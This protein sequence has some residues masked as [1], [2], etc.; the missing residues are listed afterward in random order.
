LFLKGVVVQSRGAKISTELKYREAITLYSGSDLSIKNICERTGVGFCAF[1][2]YL[3]KNHRELIIKRHNLS[4]YE[5]VKLRGRRGQTTA[6]HHKYKDAIAACDS[7]EYIE[8]NISQIARIF[9]VE[10]AALS[11][12]LR[13]HYPDIVPRREQE[14]QRLGIYVN[15]QYGVRSWAKESYR[16]AVELLQRSEMTIGEVATICNVSHS[17]LQEH[18]ISYYPNIISQREEKRQKAAG[19]KVRGKRNGNW[20]IHEPSKETIEKYAEAIELYRNSSLSVE[21][22]VAATNVN[23]G[24]FRNYLRTWHSELMVQRRGFDKGV[25]L[26]KTKRY[27]KLTAEKY[28]AAIERLRNSDLSTAR[29]AAEY[30]LNAGLFRMYVKEHYPEL[31]NARGMTTASNGKRVSA[32]SANRYAE[33]LHLYET[34]DE[35]LKSI[36]QRLGI[37]YN[38]ISGYSRRNHPE[39]IERHNALVVSPEQKFAEGVKRLQQSNDTINAVMKQLGYTES[40]R[41][42]IKE[43]YPELLSR[44]VERKKVTG[45]KV[46]SEKYAEAMELMENSSLTMVKIVEKLGLNIHSFRKYVTRQRPELKKERRNKKKVA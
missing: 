8:Y 31:T 9:N 45:T 25:A 11:N 38:S 12:Q 5:N 10:C 40:F 39:A 4:Q 13:K 33:A 21:E 1:C 36:A 14:R 37:T 3:S 42:Y 17:G 35:S 24:G 2:S 41:L 30:G 23:L 15:L 22:I 26:E 20:G 16:E 19:Q 28:A 32:R 43:N 27:N 7:I 6:A 46:A 44:K 29:V 34:T 18:I